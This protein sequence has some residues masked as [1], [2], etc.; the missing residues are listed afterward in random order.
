MSATRRRQGAVASLELWGGIECTVNRV[1]DV[2]H[3]QLSRSGH[4]ERT[5]D[6]EAFHALGLRTL[7]Y[8]CL[9]ERIA[10]R[11][12]TA[13]DW[14]WTDARLRRLQ[15]L[16]IAPIVGLIHHGS[17][18]AGTSV[19]EESFVQGLTSYASA[20]ADR[21]P[22]IDRYTPVNEPNATARF[23]TLYGHWYPHR[24][25]AGAFC[26]AMVIQCR[27]TVCA[28]AAIR[29]INPSALLIQTDDAGTI[30]STPLLGYQ[31]EFENA[32]RWLTWDLLS[33]RVGAR[34]PL[35][36]W[37]RRHGV[38][39]CE[40]EWFRRNRCPPDVIGLNYY[41]T[42][43]RYLDHMTGRY[44]AHLRGG[45]SLHDYA[46]IEAVRAADV[47]IAGHQAVL[48]NAWDRYGLPVALTEVHLGCTREEQ[49][50]WLIEAWDGAQAALAAGVN[51]RAVC[52][53]ALLGSFDWP[54]LVTRS[55]GDYEPGAFDLRSRP[56]RPTA[57]GGIVHELASGRRAS[58]AVL[59]SRGWWAR[60]D[61]SRR[62]R[63]GSSSPPRPLLVVGSAERLAAA[64]R[65]CC[66]ARGLAAVPLV[67]GW[68]DSTIAS[69]LAY[70]VETVQPWAIV[71]AGGFDD[72]DE[73]EGRADQCWRE[74]VVALQAVVAAAAAA[75]VRLVTFSSDL[76]FDGA[77]ERSYVELDAPR[78]ASVLGATQVAAER[79]ALDSD[80]QALVIRTGVILS[81]WDPPEVLAT[82]VR[83]LRGRETASD[84]RR[85]RGCLSYLPEVVD[86]MLDLLIDGEEG[87]WHL[88]NSGSC[89]WDALRD[90]CGL[91]S[92]IDT[93]D[94]GIAPRSALDTVRG[95][96]M[97]SV[98][99]A[100][101]A[102]A[103]ERA[104]T[105][106]LIA[107][108]EANQVRPRPG[109]PPM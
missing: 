39:V 96:V 78:P 4:D 60:G 69:R 36:G 103:H 70:A 80:G 7:R 10:P 38:A 52:A 6:L 90:R 95:H 65:R 74:N 81:P 97:S 45:N 33:G 30:A 93:G 26:R 15:E 92:D 76:V 64:V 9:W 24:R 85:V 13:A 62:L 47:G 46:D 31:A 68:I 11:G 35:W 94:M 55:N 56:P 99:R 87:I 44:P 5:A 108:P 72:V 89:A 101:D 34:H 82:S 63:N 59:A 98:D 51:V 3:D 8:P 21:Y 14:A 12:P 71:N 79:S 49:L 66:A 102:F 42:S 58:H 28:M 54:S 18:P 91:A 40:L 84:R 100:L 17:G 27:A 106:A 16:D 75:R 37:L 29:R 105:R 109:M 43:D 20:F 61:Q 25:D 23:S 57:L 22:W 83:S 32:R 86:T 53:W 88:A 77:E 2:W 48:Q 41:L 73:A 1:G 50:R 19:L 67:V 107:S 104:H